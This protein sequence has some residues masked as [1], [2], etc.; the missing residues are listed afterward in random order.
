MTYAPGQQ[1]GHRPR[2]FV[3]GGSASVS[4]PYS[5]LPMAGWGQTLPLFLTDAVEVVNCCRARA[6][7]KSFHERGRLQWILDNMAPGDYLL[8]GFGH[9]DTKPDP[10]L[11]T[12]PFSTFTEHMAAYV[13]GARERQGHPVIFVPYERRRIDR[14][15][16][17]AR[18]LGD[19]PLAARQL[20]ED[21]HVPLVD[22]YGQSLRW[23]EELGPEATKAVFTYLRPG[24]P[25]Q[26][27]VIDADNVH[28]RA[29]GAVECARF[30]ARSLLEQGVIP[31][32]WVRDLD[33]TRFSYEEMGWLDEE[34]FRRR[35]ASRVS[36]IP[37]S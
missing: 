22:L 20:A 14:H 23:W 13:H 29:E 30:V 4:R 19:Y 11:H 9:N 16:N 15:G 18:F 26:E 7:S 12:E 31:P 34:T 1:Q 35:T 6:S 32:H 24:E 33:R 37:G 28:V 21:E 36:P 25:L 3:A 8:F 27:Q 17:V 2:I 10:G 5:F